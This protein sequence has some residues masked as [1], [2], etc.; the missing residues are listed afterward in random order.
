[1]EIPLT[2]TCPECQQ[3]ME[4]ITSDDVGEVVV[5]ECAECGYQQETRVEK[6]DDDEDAVPVEFDP[7][8]LDPADFEDEEDAELSLDPD[9]AE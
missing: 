3:E 4:L 9:E 2:K 5:Y 6:W 1:M 7:D 8:Q